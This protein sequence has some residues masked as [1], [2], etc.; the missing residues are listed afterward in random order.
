MSFYAG[1]L[2]LTSM[3]SL[4]LGVFVVLKGLKKAPN[5]ILGLFSFALALWCFG[6]FM[7]EMVE[8]KAQV[9]FWTRIGIMGAVLIPVFFV[10]FILSLIDKFEYEKN[11][12]RVLNGLGS[13]FLVLVFTPFFVKDVVP[14]LGFRYYPE[15]GIVYP[16]FALFVLIFFVYGFTRLILSF[17]QSVG[18]KRN[19]LLYL[20]ILV[21]FHLCTF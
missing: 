14:R 6:Q 19:Q 18:S 10:H 13:V 17:R 11:L 12:L 4:L 15:A 3:A 16:F 8:I 2:L 1:S 5:I 7:G 20:I 21:S 9:L